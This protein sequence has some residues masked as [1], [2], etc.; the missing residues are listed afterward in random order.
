MHIPSIALTHIQKIAPAPPIERALATPAIFPVPTVAERA[1]QADLY[2]V[3]SLVFWCRINALAVSLMLSQNL[4]IWQNPVLKLKYNPQII[5][6]AKGKVPEIK[7]SKKPIIITIIM[8][9]NLNKKYDF[10][11]YFVMIQ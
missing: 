9:I 1:V 5:K 11:A 7:F 6:N 10:K 2:E 4:V 8:F 3:I